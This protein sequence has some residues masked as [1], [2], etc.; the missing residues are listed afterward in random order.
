M[1]GGDDNIMNLLTK[2]IM[3]R[4]M[5]KFSLYFQTMNLYQKYFIL[6]NKNKIIKLL[7]QNNWRKGLE[8]FQL[9]ISRHIKE[10]V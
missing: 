2:Y 10:S 9:V 1:N 4:N 8:L 3:S 7:E 5:S 6:K